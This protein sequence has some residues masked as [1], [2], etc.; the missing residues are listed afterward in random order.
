[1]ST[2]VHFPLT[3]LDLS[4]FI[5]PDLHH[6]IASPPPSAAA[7]ATTIMSSSSDSNEYSIGKNSGTTSVNDN[8]TTA[9]DRNITVVA[10]KLE[11]VS[12]DPTGNC[13]YNSNSRKSCNKNGNS[14]VVDVTTQLAD[15]SLITA[16]PPPVYDLIGVSN[17]H[18]NLHSGHYIAHV[19]TNSCSSN[20]NDSASAAR[21]MCFNDAR[22]SLANAA[23]VAGPTAYVLFYKLRETPTRHMNNNNNS[24]S[25]SREAEMMINT[26]SVSL[27]TQ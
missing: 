22:V 17:H 6:L 2:D 16:L 11:T 12:I 1:M 21:W 15:T 7:A 19:D 14:A 4:P 24:I 23:S 13:N 5:S 3:G 25:N 20:S 9:P 26:K 27:S 18:G 8:S 10:N